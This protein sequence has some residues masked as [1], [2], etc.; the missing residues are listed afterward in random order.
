MNKVEKVEILTKVKNQIEQNGA[1]KCEYVD[2]DG[3][4]CAVGYVFAECGVD[5][6]VFKHSGLNGETADILVTNNRNIAE[7]L[8]PYGFSG[9]ELRILQ[10]VNDNYNEELDEPERIK[11]VLRHINVMIE[12]AEEG[13]DNE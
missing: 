1:S 13:E 10:E 5:M 7:Q 2:N 8:E 12:R 11:A 4:M 3:C 6:N 9:E